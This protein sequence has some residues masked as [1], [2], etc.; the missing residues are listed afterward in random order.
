MSLLGSNLLNESKNL[1][2]MSSIQ[3]Y[4]FTFEAW[5]AATEEARKH[6]A[7]EQAMS[8]LSGIVSR[9]TGVDFKKQVG[10]WEACTLTLMN[11]TNWLVGVAHA[12][13]H[14][15]LNA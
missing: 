13:P 11:V 14:L 5:Q 10:L 3:A 7:M 8:D 4:P 2:Q 9:L 1:V 12:P 15:I 6:R